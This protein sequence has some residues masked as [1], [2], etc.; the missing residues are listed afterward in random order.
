MITI[1]ALCPLS[2]RAAGEPG[3]STAPSE[4]TAAPAPPPEPEKKW[5]EKVKFE[6]LA[7][8]YYSYRLNASSSAI[9]APSELRAFDAN[10]HAFTL[11]YA[12]LAL[13]IPADPAG[14]RID[15]GFGTVADATATDLAPPPSAA[16]EVFKHIQQAY[17]SFKLFNLITIDA[18]KFVT[19]AGSEVIEAKDNWLYSRSLLFTWAIPFAHT[20]LRIGVPF[21]DT[22]SATLQVTNGWDSQLSSLTFKT[23]GVTA[24]LN[25]PSATSIAFNFYGGPVNTSD[26][27]L[28]FDLVIAQNFGDAF[29]INL[30][31]D[32]GTEAGNSWYGA[33]LM[34]KLMVIDN[35]R[36]AARVE[37]FADPASV[38]TAVVQTSGTGG[39]SFISGTLG[40]GIGLSGLANAEIRP[41]FRVD[42][43]LGATPFLGGTE[44]TQFTAQV[45]FLA[46]F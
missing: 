11:G 33:A 21:T 27:R 19:S 29:A 6:G 40:A 39:A 15:L 31:G 32:F 3:T 5:Y 13:S 7:D 26:L 17:A 36:L 38:R 22:F 2:A 10:N 20:G 37:Y 45:G 43:A 35:V 42:T 46:W 8:A 25:L 4:G 34:A 14:F 24:A 44:A 18:G 1:T 16:L 23:F 12:E 28:L 41:E 9:R 30:N